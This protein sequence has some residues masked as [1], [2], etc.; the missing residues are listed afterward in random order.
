[1]SIRGKER[2]STWGYLMNIAS[3]IEYLRLWLNVNRQID[4]GLKCTL[5]NVNL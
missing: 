2:V 1:M 5:I 4:L 3:A